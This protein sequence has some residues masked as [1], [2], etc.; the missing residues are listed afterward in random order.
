M[1]EQ[2]FPIFGYEMYEVSSL[3]QVRRAGGK[4]LKPSL[5]SGS[6]YYTVSLYNKD[7]RNVRPLHHLVCEAFHGPRPEGFQ[8]LHKDDIKANNSAENLYWGTHQQN[9]DDAIRNG[10][11]AVAAA[12]WRG[13]V[14]VACQGT[15]MWKAK[16]NEEMVREIRRLRSTGLSCGKIAKIMPVGKS[17]IEFVVN[18]T[19]WKHVQ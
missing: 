1:Q 10:G 12:K 3:G 15:R 2:W 5:P 18:G 19:T 9:M 17:N 4:V 6:S 7:G 13:Q 16:L 11:R 8:A 14:N